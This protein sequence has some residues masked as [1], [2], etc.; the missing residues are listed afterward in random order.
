V[1]KAKM[2]EECV[3]EIGERKWG[4]DF[5]RRM[6]IENVLMYG[7]QIWGWK[8]Q[9]EVLREECKRN[10]LRVKVEKR[11]AKFVDKMEGRKKCRILTEY[12]GEKKKTRRR[13]RE[14]NTTRGTGMPVKKWKG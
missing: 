7:A 1:R 10:R 11:A 9:E 4:R 3:W 13:R 6:M 12:W 5:G 2:V 14:R 8:E